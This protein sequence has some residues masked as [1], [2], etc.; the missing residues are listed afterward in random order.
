MMNKA[1]A[2]LIPVLL[3]SLISLRVSAQQAASAGSE[4]NLPQEANAPPA[5]TADGVPLCSEQ[6]KSERLQAGAQPIDEKTVPPVPIKLPAASFT[7]KSHK[8][9]KSVMKAEHLKKFE[10]RVTVSLVVD[11]DGLPQHVCVQS[12]V[13]HGFDRSAFDAVMKYRFHPAT[14]DGKPV[15]VVLKVDAKFELY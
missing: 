15:P 1:R 14:R 8:Y 3:F 7:K 12:E 4:Q 6:F 10:A 2:Y 5:L 9:G 11:T 13:G